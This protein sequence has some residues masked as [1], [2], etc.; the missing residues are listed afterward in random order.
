[1][2]FLNVFRQAGFENQHFCDFYVEQLT[3]MPKTDN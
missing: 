1:M 2:D 3:R